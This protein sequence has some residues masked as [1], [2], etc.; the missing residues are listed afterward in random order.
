MKKNWFLITYF[1]LVP[2]SL[3]SAKSTL[4]TKEYFIYPIQHRFGVYVEAGLDKMHPI[5]Y[6]KLETNKSNPMGTIGFVYEYMNQHFILNTGVSFGFLTGKYFLLDTL[7]NTITSEEL[8][9]T[10]PNEKPFDL[11]VT[12]TKHDIVK[13]GMLEFPIMA[14]VNYKK[15]YAMAG[16]RLG[17]KVVDGTKVNG[18]IR[19][20]AKY[21][22]YISS[23]EWMPNH[24]LRAGGYEVKNKSFLTV[25]LRV[26]LEGGYNFKTIVR[27]YFNC[28]PR[29]GVFVN[30]GPYLPNVDIS[31][32]QIAFAENKYDLTS[33]NQ[34]PLLK[35]GHHMLLDMQAGVKL[36]FM[37]LDKHINKPPCKTCKQFEALKQP[38]C[39]MCEKQ[40]QRYKRISRKKEVYNHSWSE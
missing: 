12:Q 18:S 9:D 19:F 37:F 20:S 2:L 14:G 25:N 23:F 29:I 26:A 30:A 16:L 8:K 10:D 35:K 22:E 15:F 1:L 36:C 28:T 33:Y 5:N 34:Q 40:Q 39:P 38:Y 31:N 7:R 13:F 6:D 21:K 17:I 11:Y 32:Q 3:F 27:E 24:G 4:T